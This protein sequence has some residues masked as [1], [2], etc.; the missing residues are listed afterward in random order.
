MT[1]ALIT[2]LLTGFSQG[3]VSRDPELA[4]LPGLAQYQRQAAALAAHLTADLVL[5]PL[6]T[7]LHRQG[8]K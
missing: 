5:Y 6:E 3:A 2:G 1:N 4:H 7:I 8:W